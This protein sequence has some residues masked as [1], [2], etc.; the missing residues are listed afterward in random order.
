MQRFYLILL[1]ILAFTQVEASV[2]QI[3]SCAATIF[4]AYLPPVGKNE[5]GLGSESVAIK[6]CNNTNMTL[7]FNGK[8]ASIAEIL[9]YNGKWTAEQTKALLANTTTQ[10]RYNYFMQHNHGR[11]LNIQCNR[12]I[13]NVNSC[14]AALFG[15]S[16][17]EIDYL[18]CPQAENQYYIL[19]PKHWTPYLNK[20]YVFCA[21]NYKLPHQCVD[22]NT[23]IKLITLPH[24]LKNGS[25]YTYTSREICLFKKYN[26]S[27]I[28]TYL[29]KARYNYYSILSGF[30]D[31]QRLNFNR[32]KA[33]SY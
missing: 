31:E 11:P 10:A 14:T 15:N 3:N 16:K 28:Q 19:S 12:V 33:E 4:D 7:F 25:Y 29:S 9:Q 22:E 23:A 26:S 30:E 24:E 17:Y 5:C 2:K 18:L 20:L 1:L 27:F 6:D 13:K 32:D 21:A 8:D